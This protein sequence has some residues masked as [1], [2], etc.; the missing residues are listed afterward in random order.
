MNSRLSAISLAA[1]TE[2]QRDCRPESAEEAGNI[3]GPNKVLEQIG[4]GGYRNVHM[5][6]Q[7]A[8]VRRRVALTIIKFG[9]AVWLS[10]PTE[11]P[12]QR[13]ITEGGRPIPE[14]SK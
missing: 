13:M 3:I 5:A 12:P 8:P 10:R 14:P 6:D 11:R 7:Y 9:R 4:E 2:S 1:V